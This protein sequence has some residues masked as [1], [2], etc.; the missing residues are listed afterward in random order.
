MNKKTTVVGLA[1]VLAMCGA[2]RADVELPS[3][4]GDN[5]VL[6]RETSAAIW[7]WDTPES[8]VTVSFRG[9][10]YSAKAGADGKWLTRVASGLAG[11][12][13]S[14]TIKGSTTVALKNIAVG[15]VWIAGGQSNM[16]W[17]VS[18]GKNAAEEA[19]NGDYPTIRVWDANLTAP[20]QGGY[21]ATSPQRTVNAQW[22]TAT[23]QNVP[24]F[25]G[26]P[27]FFARD[28]QKKL[29]VPV[30]IVHLAVPGTDIEW[31]MNPATVNRML[32][33]HVE[34]EV[35]QKQFYPERKKAYDE[36]R[37]AWQTAKAEAEKA[38]RPVPQ[39]PKALRTPEEMP[40]AGM[41][42]NGMVSPAAPFTAKGFLWWQGE[43]NGD[44]AAQYRT[45]FPALIDDWRKAWGK[46]AMPF[47]YVELANFG[48]RQGNSRPVADDAWPA[49]RDAQRSALTM[50]D[51]YRISVIDILDEEGP[52]WNIHPLNKQLAGNRLYLTALANV[53]GDKTVAWSGPVYNSAT[54][55]GNAATVSFSHAA[56][57]KPREGTELKG[58]ALAGADRKWSWAQAKI[59]GD[60]VVLSSNDVP[61]PVAVRYG[62]HINPLSN[63]VNGANLPAAPFRSDRWNLQP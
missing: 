1:L 8:N 55:E 32:P 52:I 16:W 18:S 49:L 53:Y 54:F 4:I 25:P 58:F 2:A 29:G 17:H 41:F 28:L 50:S 21:R 37:L 46:D 6:Q 59:V 20:V 57:L 14:L 43:N 30:G 34:L 23:P 12:E 26:V 60:I 19:K 56:G 27:Y 10:E 3:V 33:Q 63:L 39:E 9:R 11:S 44:R 42:Y 13:F 22:K 38:G 7:G 62:W 40:Y 48:F 36:A 51:T 31:H 5:M 47:L 35:L 15:E 24:D 45:L 61:Q